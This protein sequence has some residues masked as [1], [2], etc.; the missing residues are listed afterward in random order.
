MMHRWP[1]CCLFLWTWAAEALNVPPYDVEI[2]SGA[3]GIYPWQ[4]R[5]FS[6]HLRSPRVNFLKWSSE[7]DDG[8]FYFIS[9]RGW[10][11]PEPGPVMLDGDG[12]LLWTEHF[13]N[14]FGKQVYDFKVQK[15]HGE[16]H[17]TFWVGD[18]VVNG[19]GAGEFFMV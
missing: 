10:K 1:A 6:S 14:D 13:A 17:L 16:D 4:P 12:T 19:H 3:R 8:L 5:F 7:C 11:V 2:D 18:D 15:Y 9:P